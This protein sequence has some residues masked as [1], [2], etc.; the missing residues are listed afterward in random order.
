VD[1]SLTKAAP[2][3]TKPSAKKLRR[4]GSADKL[5]QNLAPVGA[6][7]PSLDLFHGLGKVLYCKRNDDDDKAESLPPALAH[8]QR[9]PLKSNPE[10]IL[11]RAPVSEETFTG[12]LQQNYP[13]FFTDIGELSNAAESLSI[14]EPFFTQWTVSF[15]GPLSVCFS[16]IMGSLLEFRKGFSVRIRRTRR[17]SR[18]LL[19]QRARC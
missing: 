10:D 11:E 19:S 9:K 14:S 12:F 1:G 17:H 3:K 5:G 7:D 15:K 2:A 4:N 6:K 18:P 8:A 16:H 13:S